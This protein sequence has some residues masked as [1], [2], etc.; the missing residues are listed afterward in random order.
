MR[1]L[2]FLLRK[3]TDHKNLTIF[4]YIQYLLFSFLNIFSTFANCYREW[5]FERPR[6]VQARVPNPA[7]HTKRIRCKYLLLHSHW[8]SFFYLLTVYWFCPF[9]PI[10]V[11]LLSTSCVGFF[12]T[13]P[14]KTVTKPAATKEFVEGEIWEYHPLSNAPFRIYA[15]G[16]AERGWYC[17]EQ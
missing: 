4:V 17:Q 14:E 10:E 12:A 8:E 5:I 7:G 16:A 1:T 15:V 3:K 13:T 6:S 11:N 2:L 9:K